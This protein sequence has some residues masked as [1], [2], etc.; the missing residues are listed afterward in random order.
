MS[1]SRSSG[2]SNSNRSRWKFTEQTMIRVRINSVQH[3]TVQQ[4]DVDDTTTS[5]CRYLGA[6]YTYSSQQ[7]LYIDIC[8]AVSSCFIQV[9]VRQ[10]AAALYRHTY[11]SQQLLYIG[12]RTAASSCYRSC[13]YSINCYFEEEMLRII[14]QVNSNSQH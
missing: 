2:M 9:Y 1:C 11:S 8:T 7:L 3:S 14:Q 13:A 12:I 5:K 4:H 10:S 6:I